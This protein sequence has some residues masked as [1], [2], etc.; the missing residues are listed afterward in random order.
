MTMTTSRKS[1]LQNA[2]IDECER[3]VRDFQSA[4]L[5]IEQIVDNLSQMFSGNGI[6]IMNVVE[7]MSLGFFIFYKD[8]F[9]LVFDN[10]GLARRTRIDDESAC[11]ILSKYYACRSLAQVPRFYDQQILEYTREISTDIRKLQLGIG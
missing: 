11:R 5:N 7:D 2:I 6:R 10:N 1:D 9:I 3:L 4:T 8:G